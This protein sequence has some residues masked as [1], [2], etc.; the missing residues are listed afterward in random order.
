VLFIAD[1]AV[2][3]GRRFGNVLSV[4]SDRELPVADLGRR[5]ASDPFPGRVEHGTA[6]SDFTGGAVPVTDATAVASPEP[7][8]GSFSF[9]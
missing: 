4:A 7:P 9:K 6:V 2:L 3:R 8:A 1:P 5:T